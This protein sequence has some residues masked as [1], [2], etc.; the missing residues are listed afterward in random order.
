MP[1]LFTSLQKHDLGHL[2][3]VAGLWG[4]ELGSSETEAALKELCASLLDPDLLA[5]ILEALDPE[6]R[7]A[8][9]ALAAKNGRVPWAEFTRRFGDIREMGAG[10]RDREK[11]HLNP[12]ST[13]EI[14]FYR[15]LLARA[16]FNTASGP[17][18]FA[19]LPNDLL[20]ILNREDRKER[21][22]EKEKS[23]APFADLAVNPESLG[24]P[25]SPI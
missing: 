9:E 10:K 2:R 20:T 8:L 5:E 7:A 4:L 14:L 21:E 17:Q 13:A 25:A 19:Y 16:F 18:E 24:R 12:A 15:A 11:P 22:G 1:D 3:I 6:A 23:L